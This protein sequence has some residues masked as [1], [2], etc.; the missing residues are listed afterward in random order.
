MAGSLI[1]VSYQRD[2]GGFYALTRDESNSRGQAVDSGGVTRQPLFKEAATPFVGGLP[3]QGFRERYA[4]TFLQADPRVRRKFPI[5]NPLAIAVLSEPGAFITASIRTNEANSN[6]I[7]TSIRG[8]RSPK[9]VNF[10][11][12]TGQ[13]DGTSGPGIT[14]T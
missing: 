5:G 4:N 12:D 7:V 2:S 9:N 1:G 11:S 10:S 6:W 13:T 8:E 14:G 3:P